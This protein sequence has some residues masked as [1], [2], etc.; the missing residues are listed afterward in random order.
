MT[1][2]INGGELFAHIRKRGKLSVEAS[3]FIGMEVAC[4]LQSVHDYGVVY[5]A[6]KPENIMLGMTARCYN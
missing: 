6:I 5:R 2:F 1:E 4:A 3:K